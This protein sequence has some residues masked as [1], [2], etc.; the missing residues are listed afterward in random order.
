MSG[1]PIKR[2]L[3]GQRKKRLRSVRS[4]C[5]C[6]FAAIERAAIVAAPS[7]PSECRIRSDV[8]SHRYAIRRQHSILRP[9]VAGRACS[10]RASIVSR[11]RPRPHGAG[12][13]RP[14]PQIPPVCSHAPARRGPCPCRRHLVALTL[15]GE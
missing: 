15:Q 8:C 3:R 5:A 12:A 1:R 11:R 14:K 2:T 13:E 10:R 9:N 7:V 6:A 4:R